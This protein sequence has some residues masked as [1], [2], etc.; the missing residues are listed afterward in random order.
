MKKGLGTQNNLKPE[1]IKTML[2]INDIKTAL[3]VN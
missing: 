1:Q 2:H 3:N